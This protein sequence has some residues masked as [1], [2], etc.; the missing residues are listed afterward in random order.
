MDGLTE[1]DRMAL[2]RYFEI[3][4]EANQ[5]NKAKVESQNV[6]VSSPSQGVVSGDGN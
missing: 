6:S 2:I 1:E 5:R 3:L 4:N